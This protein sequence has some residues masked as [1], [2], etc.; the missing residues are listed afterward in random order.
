M[1]D[2]TTEK[3]YI[4]EEVMRLLAVKYPRGLYEWLD[5]H[6]RGAY[7]E[8]NRLEDEIKPIF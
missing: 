1:R 2:V 3:E 5:A 4:L 8:V 7:D 6:D